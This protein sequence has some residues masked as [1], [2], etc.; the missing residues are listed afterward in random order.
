MKGKKHSAGKMYHKEKGAITVMLSLLLVPV[1]LFTGLMVDFSRVKLYESQAVYS[2]D[3]YANSILASYN[4]ELY[5]MYA[6][7]GFSSNEELEK[8]LANIAKNSF[9]GGDP[10]DEQGLAELIEFIGDTW[11]GS[12]EEK[13]VFIPY[14]NAK[15]DFS[16]SVAENKDSE[17]GTLGNDKILKTQI[18]DY[19]VTRLPTLIAENA[20]DGGT[21][22]I[23]DIMSAIETVKN[24]DKYSRITAT[25]CKLDAKLEDFMNYLTAYHDDLNSLKSESFSDQDM[26]NRYLVNYGKYGLEELKYIIGE[27]SYNSGKPNIKKLS[28]ETIL[29]SIGN[30][31]YQTKDYNKRIQ[32]IIDEIDYSFSISEIKELK[33]QLN[34]IKKELSADNNFYTVCGNELV[35]HVNDMYGL[36]YRVNCG[37]VYSKG[38]PNEL[39]IKKLRNKSFIDIA[40]GLDSQKSEINK[41]IQDLNKVCAE[42]VQ[43]GCDEELVQEMCAD[44]ENIRVLAADG[45]SYTEIAEKYLNMFNAVLSSALG[46]DGSA[47]QIRKVVYS[48]DNLTGILHNDYELI[49][50]NVDKLINQDGLAIKFADAKIKALSNNSNDDKEKKYV[51]KED[52][53]ESD[54]LVDDIVDYYVY[55]VDQYNVFGH[56]YESNFTPIFKGKVVYGLANVE[57]YFITNDD[58]PVTVYLTDQKS[59]VKKISEI[60]EIIHNS[61]AGTSVNSN[62]KNSVLKKAKSLLNKMDGVSLDVYEENDLVISDG[63]SE[64]LSS[65]IASN[66]KKKNSMTDMLNNIDSFFPDINLADIASDTVLTLYDY[67]MFSCDTTDKIPK[68]DNSNNNLSGDK[69]SVVGSDGKFLLGDGEEECT[70]LSNLA[71]GVS[72]DGITNSNNSSKGSKNLFYSERSEKEREESMTDQVYYDT[73]MLYRCELE[74]LFVG[75][76]V[77]QKNLDNTRLTIIAERMVFNYMSTYTTKNL[78]NALKAINKSLSLAFTPAVGIVTEG[79]LRIAIAAVETNSDMTLLLSG[80]SIVLLKSDFEDFSSYGIL[81]NMLNEAQNEANDL[82]KDS[83]KTISQNKTDEV[84]KASFPVIKMNYKKHLLLNILLFT[85]KKTLLDRTRDIMDLNVNKM[86]KNLEVKDNSIVFAGGLTADDPKYFRISNQ[87]TVIDAKC[88]VQMSP[89]FASLGLDRLTNNSDEVNEYLND[90]RTYSVIKGY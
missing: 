87:T 40:N 48:A 46:G 43:S 62:Q 73:S 28:G 74:Y 30:A 49:K 58:R 85:N 14:R 60:Y 7:F 54:I 25:K 71:S 23:E 12:D 88:S 81:K 78:N 27:F 66:E 4:D 34:K 44:Y 72:S 47:S 21:S 22:D 5:N 17:K 53:F 39:I 68:N 82:S 6:L 26:Y 31:V 45:F 90:K 89:L 86:E 1:I 65:T 61:C 9:N 20:I 52:F 32:E 16:Y 13:N 3:L 18:T 19:T 69:K 38:N 67:N 64:A 79:V 37:N 51:G 83:G 75:N 10:N 76:K 11:N 50:S 15:V 8:E 2:A 63:V 36:A 59:T 24:L 70:P 41:L 56:I 80:D 29:D 55:A 84:S 42:A 35:D 77:M 57:F 33:I